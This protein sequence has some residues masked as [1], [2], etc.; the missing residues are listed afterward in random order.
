MNMLAFKCR[1]C[2]DGPRIECCLVNSQVC[3]LFKF[4]LSAFIIEKI[5]RDYKLNPILVMGKHV[6]V[7]YLPHYRAVQNVAV[8]SSLTSKKIKS[9]KHI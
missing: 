6:F 3:N 7:S 4:A 9:A 8:K 2:G 5:D 1:F